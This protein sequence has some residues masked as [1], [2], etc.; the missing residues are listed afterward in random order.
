MR[1]YVIFVA[2]IG[3][4]LIGCGGSDQESATT[5][6]GS[7]STAG[8][9]GG[10]GGSG[11]GGSGSG[12][13]PGPKCSSKQ[14]TLVKGVNI[15]DVA[16]N[17]TDVFYTVNN[18]DPTNP[19][20]VSSVPIRGG[21][22]T[23]LTPAAMPIGVAL[24]DTLVIFGDEAG[25]IFT[26]PIAGGTKK[27]IA[28]T[29]GQ[30][31][32]LVIDATNVYFSDDVGTKSVPIAG[33][34]VK[35]LS[36]DVGFSL[37]IDGDQ[38]IIADFGGGNVL[39][40]PRTGG[41]TK[42]LAKMQG[43]PL[44]PVTVGKNLVWIDA[45]DLMGGAGTLMQLSPGG[46]PTAISMGGALY[47][48]HGLVY[49]GTNFYVTADAGPDLAKVPGGGGDPVVVTNLAGDAGLAVD[50]ECLYVAEPAF[51]LISLAK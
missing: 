32:H 11:G 16:V 30:P 29:K 15:D 18:G 1:A 36:S 24:T 8:G 41:A 6:S 19:G 37:A 34:A 20:S 17:A 40:V 14:T 27:K 4:A 42:T 33:G 43:G 10:T 31:A 2:A 39:S 26:V 28:P 23:V 45:G 51:G 12:G 7:S 5:T 38:L 21:K 46:A 44:Y 35:T 3:A 13:S 50:D 49:D 47:R 25:G 9:G 48:P 22:V